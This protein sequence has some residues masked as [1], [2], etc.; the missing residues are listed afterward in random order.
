MKPDLLA[1]AVLQMAPHATQASI[2]SSE[3]LFLR[4]NGENRTNLKRLI[5]HQIPRLGPARISGAL[6]QAI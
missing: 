2:L 4:D 6:R 5:S 3:S 1:K